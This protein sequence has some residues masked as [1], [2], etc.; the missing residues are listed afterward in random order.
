MSGI[1][2]KFG[3]ADADTQSTVDEALGELLAAAGVSA[4]VLPLKWGKIVIEAADAPAAQSVRYM[5]TQIEELLVE[6]DVTAD[7]EVRVSR[8]SR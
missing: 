7:V 5:M 4:T 2:S 1:T 6:R 8:N 3:V